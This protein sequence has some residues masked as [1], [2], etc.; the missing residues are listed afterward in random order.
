MLRID[1]HAHMIP[2]KFVEGEEVRFPADGGEPHVMPLRPVN[3]FDADTIYSVER[4]LHDMDDQGLDMHVIS[5]QPMFTPLL[6]VDRAVQ[7]SRQI[8]DAFAEVVAANPK[9]FLALADLPMQSP[10][11]AAREFERAVR[12][13]GLRGTERARR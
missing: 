6:P 2:A 3:N 11:D 9:R 5:L 4:R 1:V 12:E 13:L 10:E 7:I 8:N